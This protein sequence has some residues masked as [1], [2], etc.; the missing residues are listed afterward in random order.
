[1][2]IKAIGKKDKGR[3][4]FLQCLN[5]FSLV[6]YHITGLKVRFVFW[7]EGFPG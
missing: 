6:V 2:K 1:M 3:S 5:F 4:D 7:V